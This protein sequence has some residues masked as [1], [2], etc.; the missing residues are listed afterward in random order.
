MSQCLWLFD[1]KT[2]H[3]KSLIHQLAPLNTIKQLKWNPIYVD[4]F[5]FLSTVTSTTSINSQNH[6]INIYY[7]RM[8]SLEIIQVP[9]I[10]FKVCS[11]E[12]TSDGRSLVL[13]DQDKFCI[14]F[15]LEE[16]VSILE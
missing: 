15:P 12:W 4:Q 16:S 9:I 14:A 2:L 1:M 10:G 11:L 6:A 8:E 3:Q 7:Y 5:V 13:M